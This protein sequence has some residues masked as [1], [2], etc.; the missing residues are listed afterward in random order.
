MLEWLKKKSTEIQERNVQLELQ[1][2]IDLSG[3]GFEE[4]K[5]VASEESYSLEAGLNEAH[6]LE[7]SK[8]QKTLLSKMI[9]PLSKEELQVK[10]FDPILNSPDFHEG[11]KVVLQQVLDAF[12]PKTG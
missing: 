2:L 4:F 7:V 12:Q 3:R 10:Y 5:K 1:K 9:G 6:I 11:V 8:Q